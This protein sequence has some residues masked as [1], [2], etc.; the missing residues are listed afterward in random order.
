MMLGNCYMDVIRAVKGRPTAWLLF[1]YVLDAVRNAVEQVAHIYVCLFL[2]LF[3]TVQHVLKTLNLRRQLLI[4]PALPDRSL[5]VSVNQL[6][7]KESVLL[8][9]VAHRIADIKITCQD[10]T[11]I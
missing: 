8:K 9:D 6:K 3:D 11:C 7:G 5:P 2:L 10:S 1:N 4:S